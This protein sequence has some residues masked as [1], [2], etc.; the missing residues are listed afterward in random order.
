V[1]D[2]G[3]ASRKLYV[4]T[5]RERKASSRIEELFE[6]ERAR[7]LS[8]EWFECRDLQEE[9]NGSRRTEAENEVVEVV[10]KWAWF[11]IG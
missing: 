11:K 10:K 6:S 9:K 7:R 1:D 8:D 3:D 2:L 4:A 5:G